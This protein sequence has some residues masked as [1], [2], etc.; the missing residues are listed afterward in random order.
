MKTYTY[1]GLTLTDVVWG[2]SVSI[3]RRTVDVVR[4]SSD[5]LMLSEPTTVRS[6]QRFEDPANQGPGQPTQGRPPQDSHGT[7]A[8]P[9]RYLRVMWR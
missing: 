1:L 9:P 7:Q 3:G 6:P 4:H 8:P 2:L 5:L